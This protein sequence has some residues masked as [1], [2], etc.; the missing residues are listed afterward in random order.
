[1]KDKMALRIYNYR[2]QWHWCLTLRNRMDI[3]RGR[4][5]ETLGTFYCIQIDKKTL[6]A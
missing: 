6:R 2:T 5:E 4:W 3:D 1:M